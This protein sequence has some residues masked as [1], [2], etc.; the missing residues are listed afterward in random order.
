MRLLSLLLLFLP[1][2]FLPP[3]WAGDGAPPPHAGE[4]RLGY[5]YDPGA[6]A[7]RPVRGIPGAALVD[8]PI[9]PGFPAVLASAAPAG[10]VALAV[11]A[12]D[13]VVR[14]IDL[15]S[16]AASP[17]A[18]AMAQPDTILFSPSGAAAL[19]YSAAAGRMQAV[20]GL[21]GQAS[22]AD[23]PAVSGVPLA[24]A[25]DGAAVVTA[26]ADAAGIWFFDNS[27]PAVPLPAAAVAA[28]FRRGAHDALAATASGDVYLFDAGSGQWRQVY[29]GDVHTQ[30]PAGVQ[31]A[32]SG[33]AAWVASTGGDI[34]TIDLAGGGAKAVSCGCTPTAFEPL[35]GS[36]YR[37]TGA[38]DPLLWIWDAARATPGVRFVPRGVAQ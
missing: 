27:W 20:T 35:S 18:G 6:G 15:R 9:D 37:L 5:L 26:T 16:L 25:D 17:V 28:A 19:L 34:S 36:V 38:S 29:T 14:R 8:G 32:A 22:A 4:P 2:I 10:D 31:F 1:A 13:G 11:S 33:T 24:I 7:L 30:N 23:L 3:I 21:G 12:G